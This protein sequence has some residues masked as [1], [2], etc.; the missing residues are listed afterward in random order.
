MFELYLLSHDREETYKAYITF[1]QDKVSVGIYE[2]R[3]AHM[4][5]HKA[6][7]YNKGV[8][9]LE[10]ELC[11]IRFHTTIWEFDGHMYMIQGGKTYRRK[12]G[13]INWEL[14]N[15]RCL[16]GE[17]LRFLLSRPVRITARKADI[18]DDRIVYYLNL[19]NR[20][21]SETKRTA[22]STK[23]PGGYLS[24]DFPI[25]GGDDSLLKLFDTKPADDGIIP[26]CKGKD[27]LHRMLRY[28]NSKSAAEVWHYCEVLTK[29]L[30]NGKWIITKPNPRDIIASDIYKLFSEIVGYPVKRGISP[31]VNSKEDLDKVINY[32]KDAKILSW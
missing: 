21:G 10:K 16:A 5:F 3:I 4:T 19:L 15:N 9:R 12:L 7:E 11:P 18:P 30:K 2:Q 27:N 32:L 26:A 31:E 23:L 1:N 13:C 25:P 14:L 8:Q 24:L 29:Q 20:D 6:E 28:L 17:A 22:M